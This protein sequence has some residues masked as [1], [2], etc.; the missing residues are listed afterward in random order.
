MKKL[1]IVND[2][3]LGLTYAS[4]KGNR[5]SIIKPDEDVDAPE[6]AGVITK[7]SKNE[8]AQLEEKYNEWLA[9]VN[10]LAEK[11]SELT[12]NIKIKQNNRELMRKARYA[13]T[14]NE[15]PGSR[16]VTDKGTSFGLVH[17]IFVFLLFL[18]I[19]VYYGSG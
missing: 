10:Q 13:A 9:K 7:S 16:A 2:E 12:N 1:K 11:K 19:G 15:G 17:I 8:I 18:A 14:G 5:T 6:N 3:T 4:Y